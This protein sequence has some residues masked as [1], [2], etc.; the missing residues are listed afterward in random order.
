MR[1]ASAAILVLAASCGG[2]GFTCDLSSTTGVFNVRAEERNGG[3]CGPLPDTQAY[4][5]DLFAGP[6]EWTCETVS[7]E[8]SE[9][10]CEIQG[11]VDCEIPGG[12]TVRTIFTLTQT[13]ADTGEAVTAYAFRDSAGL[14]ICSST[15]DMTLSRQ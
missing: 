12:N 14:S 3:T 4:V 7:D 10:D 13:G 5:E 9:D 2:G 8:R 15:Y 11:V 6:D 1:T